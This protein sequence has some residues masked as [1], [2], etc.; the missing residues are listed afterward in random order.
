[1]EDCSASKDVQ[2][3]GV[4]AETLS[5]D[6]KEASSASGGRAAVAAPVA[7]GMP[8]DRDLPAPDAS[9]QDSSVADATV[10]A[11]RVN[12]VATG[13][14]A[15]IALEVSATTLTVAPASSTNGTRDQHT[16]PAAA[17][18]SAGHSLP[19]VGTRAGPVRL[20]VGG[21]PP[22]VDDND[23]KRHFG[24][25]GELLEAQVIKDR[26]TGRSRN[27][28]FVMLADPSKQDLVLREPHSIGGRRVSV[29]LHQ[30]MVSDFAPEPVASRG[31]DAEMKKVFIGRLEQ[32]FTVDMLRDVFCRKFGKV[33]DVFLANGKK[34]GFVTFETGQS[35]KAALD[36]SSTDV[37]GVTV[38]IKSAD[39]MKDSAGG[40]RGGSRGRDSP[41][42]E[43]LP[44]GA[45]GAY[46]YG[47]YG[48]YGAPP[49][50]YTTAAYYGAYPPPGYAAAPAY[51]YAAPGYAYPPGGYGGYGAYVAPSYGYG[52]GMYP[53]Q[54]AGSG[55]H[56][57]Y[58]PAPSSARDGYGRPY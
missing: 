54:P 33:A 35:A 51:G 24:S 58:G 14:G 49:A 46:P 12:A 38:V 57:A 34:F 31:V 3:A 19:A 48:C 17:S 29:K 56:G 9:G 22:E 4:G 25:F 10:P 13:S 7:H 43:A 37:D 16:S 1:M 36:A 6:T 8:C 15:A 23:L 28:G 44:P 53:Q 50:A 45:Y 5:S 11:A 55:T 20:F 26:G 27:F 39:P 2:G 42:R 41:P 32:H 21:L 52:Y 30:D 47:S 40:V 18:E